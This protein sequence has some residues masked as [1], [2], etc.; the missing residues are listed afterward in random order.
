MFF[1]V[2]KVGLLA[3]YVALVA[4]FVVAL[5]LPAEVLHW[6]RIVAAVLLAVHVM[7]AVALIGKL[8]RHKGPLADS[9]ALTLLFGVLHWQRLR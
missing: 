7:E 1:S 6:A 5:P 3:F 2:C 9:V 8:K 4:S